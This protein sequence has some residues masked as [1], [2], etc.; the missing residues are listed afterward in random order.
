MARMYTEPD[1]LLSRFEHT[2]PRIYWAADDSLLISLLGWFYVFGD[3][4][5]DQILGLSSHRPRRSGW[6]S[7]RPT[8]GGGM[9][10]CQLVHLTQ[11]VP[12]MGQ[13]GAPGNRPK[14]GCD[15]LFPEGA[16]NNLL[17]KLCSEY[18]FLK[19]GQLYHQ[20]MGVNIWPS[21]QF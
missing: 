5:I 15:M 19:R 8:R 6:P 4:Q 21:M 1:K 2:P 10:R 12:L 7:F 14:S 20:P 3:R 13:S 17:R 11:I 16:H 9:S 18:P